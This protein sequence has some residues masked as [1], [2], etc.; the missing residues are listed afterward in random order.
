MIKM[1]D[2][3]NMAISYCWFFD[4]EQTHIHAQEAHAHT[5]THT[6]RHTN[7]PTH[8]HGQTH[9][10]THTHTHARMH[11]RTAVSVVTYNIHLNLSCCLWYIPTAMNI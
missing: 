5:R 4:L 9:K 2:Q 1:L 8:T 3:E 10:H 7:T 6:D 11:A